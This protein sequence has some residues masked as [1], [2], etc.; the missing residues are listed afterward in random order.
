VVLPTQYL[1]LNAISANKNITL[2]WK[3]NEQ[4]DNTSFTIERSFDGSNFIPVNAVVEKTGDEQFASYRTFD[5]APE[6]AGDTYLYYRVKQADASGKITYS[7]LTYVH[8]QKAV[9]EIIDSKKIIK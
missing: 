9:G 5:I 1:S 2:N 6:F 4:T 8:L 7:N 3:T